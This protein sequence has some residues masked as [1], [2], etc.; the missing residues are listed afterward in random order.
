MEQ[1]AV[2]LLK[3]IFRTGLFENPYLNVEETKAIVGNPEFM[4]AG[5][6]AQLKSVV[7]LKNKDQVMPIAREKKVYIPQRYVPA[8]QS[9]FG[10]PIPARWEDPIK[11]DL[12]KNYFNIAANPEEADMAIV[13]I[14]NPENGRTAGY[15]EELAKTGDNGF[16]P[17]SLQYDTY[18]A[19]EA[20]DPSLAGDSR[21]GD[22]LNRTYRNKT[23]TAN[24]VSD[25]KMIRETVEKMNGKPVIVILRMINPAVVAEFESEV[26]G[27]IANFRVQDQAI[28]DIISGKVEPSGLLPL[29]MPA[30]MAT[31]E[32][33]FED[34]PFDMTP[35]QDS[36]G[37]T[38]DFGFGLNWSG[39]IADE[40][41]AKYE[42]GE[43]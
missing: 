6:E 27:L 36:E 33:Q 19:T 39:V 25:L 30:N 5:F 24:N 26:T 10:A 32:Q 29:Q 20:R 41:T 31:V 37:N 28:L 13:V 1:S 35:H 3:N 8:A 42:R 9:F 2:R 21:P 14:N 34:V 22:V 23:V 17:I 16:L 11:P 43:R 12:A 18:T 40:R 15:S 7:M 38:Y 4:K